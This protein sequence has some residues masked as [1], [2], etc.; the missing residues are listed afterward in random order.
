MQVTEALRN[1]LYVCRSDLAGRLEEAAARQAQVEA[2]RRE[3]EEKRQRDEAEA[4]N[5][6]AQKTRN[7]ISEL[8]DV[9]VE[10]GFGN[11]DPDD[12]DQ[13]TTIARVR[14]VLGNLADSM[15]DPAT[16]PPVVAR[17]E[18][19]VATEDACSVDKKCARD[20][21]ARRAAAR[22]ARAAERQAQVKAEAERKFVAEVVEPL[23]EAQSYMEQLRIAIRQERANPAGV[24]DLSLLHD[25]GQQLQNNQATFQ[26]LSATYVARRHHAFPGYR[27]ERACQTPPAPSGSAAPAPARP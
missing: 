2:D 26:E 1:D 16:R 23:C 18:Q 14:V 11:L 13:A 19:A 7:L 10:G 20:R 17:V 12:A 6:E 24:V 15:P 25:Y 27:S 3:Q 5:I 4:A 21:T 8:Q 22:Q 9:E